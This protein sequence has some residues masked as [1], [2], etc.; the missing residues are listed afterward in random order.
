M[1]P[2]RH[3]SE[4]LR[5]YLF[6]IRG[7]PQSGLD[8]ATINIM[9]GRDHGVPSYTAHRE[10]CGLG[11][12]FS[13][14]DLSNEMSSS[15]IEALSSVY[16]SVDDIDL[17]TGIISEKPIAGAVVGPTAACII[18][19]QFS[20][21]KKCDR[22]Y[23]ENDGPQRFS[24]EILQFTVMISHKLTSP[25]GL[26][27]LRCRAVTVYNC[28]AIADKFSSKEMMKSMNIHL[29]SDIELS[30]VRPIGFRSWPEESVLA[31]PVLKLAASAAAAVFDPSMTF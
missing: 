26:R 12:A 22:F 31:L 19:E 1:A 16:E 14:I 25:S 11:Q 20:R 2:D 5:N 21:I 3:V 23:Y 10:L 9:R 27:K 30:C 17:F 24:P 18:A 7:N 28:Q 6:A 8:L 15:T 29:E 13:F 4:A